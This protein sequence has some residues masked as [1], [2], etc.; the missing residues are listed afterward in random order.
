MGRF[1]DLWM[2]NLD[3]PLGS[4]GFCPGFV[5]DLCVNFPPY[6]HYKPSFQFQCVS[7]LIAG[8]YQ[9]NWCLGMSFLFFQ[10]S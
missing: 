6:K 1:N 10:V 5:G 8:V 3:L 4:P 2:F 7:Q 9:S